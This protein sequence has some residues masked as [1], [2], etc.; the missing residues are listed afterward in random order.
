[1]ELME[2][3]KTCLDARVN[4][5]TYQSMPDEVWLEHEDFLEAFVDYDSIAIS[6]DNDGE[7]LHQL[8]AEKDGIIFKAYA[9]ASELKG[10]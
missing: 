4:I 6:S 8:S 10:S 2:A 7:A 5:Q 9:W 3:I 1:M